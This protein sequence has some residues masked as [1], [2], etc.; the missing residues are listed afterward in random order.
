M[1]RQKSSPTIDQNEKFVSGDGNLHKEFFYRV[2]DA[3]LDFLNGNERDKKVLQYEKPEFF[4]E[5]F[6][7]SLPNKGC[8][9]DTLLQE[10]KNIGK[11]S[12]SQSDLNYIAFPDSGN[13][14]A[15]FAGE[16]YSKFLNQNL[17]AYDRS[18]PAATF[19]EIQ[20]IEWLRELVGYES[21]KS[22]NIENLAEVSG[23]WT[24]GGHMSNHMAILAAIN[25]KYPEIKAKGLSSLPF[26]PKLVLAGKIS[27]YSYSSAM[28]HLGLGN[29]NIISVES[30]PDFT[31][32]VKSLRETLKQHASSGDVFM[33]VAV[34]GNCR[35]SS[36][37]N[38]KEIADVCREYGVWLH[39]DACHG[40]SLLFSK[41]LKE[42]YLTGI[43]DADSISLD[44]HKGLFVTYPSSYVIFKQRD[45]L[46]SYT[47]YEKQ[48]RSGEAWDIGY[49][50]PFFGSRGFESLKVWLL[51]KHLG[52]KGIADVAEKRHDDA[53]YV[54]RLIKESE[55]FC[56][57]NEMSFYR[58]A[59]VYFPENIRQSL[60]INELPS[61]IVSK[62]R[63]CVDY[64]THKIN[65]ELYEE[66]SVCLDEFK[67][68]DIANVTGVADDNER[69]YVMSVTIGNPLFTKASLKKSLG[70]LFEKAKT[71]SKQ[72]DGDIN[73]ILNEKQVEIG[74]S[75]TYGPAGWN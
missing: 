35:T 48:V 43:E 14:T 25:H 2:I 72:M 74:V 56:L 67:L 42:K 31:T 45:T 62:I 61:D 18:A 32:N 36:I 65:Q 44:P 57:L 47:R 8:G 15:G 52:R 40:G 71:Y 55:Y 49:I 12:I 16:I 68:H 9:L 63:K 58:M 30:N 59:F 60:K 24:T 69:F 29:D 21:K 73:K 20:L 22:G 4:R 39:V 26:A 75:K 37:D 34:A 28:H 17:I 19:V 33:T 46:V 27:H 6:G 66:G 10:L 70:Y 11:Y 53:K 3:G 38:L 7:Y 5:M 41:K 13:S 51:I 1:K 54:E 23:M 50:T 64:Y